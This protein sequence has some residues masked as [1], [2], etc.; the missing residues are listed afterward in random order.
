MLS[1][2]LCVMLIGL[3][4]CTPIGTSQPA[5]EL[6]PT[7]SLTVIPPTPT[8]ITPTLTDTPS[9]TPSSTHTP[10][11]TPT[12]T[13]SF[14][15]TES[16]TPTE[17]STPT[18]PPATPTPVPT[19]TATLPP[20]PLY[21]NTPLQPWE[22]EAF[23]Q[24]LQDS[25]EAVQGFYDYFGPVVGGQQGNCN[26]YW[27]YYGRWESRPGFTEVPDDWYPLYYRYRVILDNV[28]TLTDPITKV[29]SG[30]GGEVPPETD[31][32]ILAGLL[33]AVGQLDQVYAEAQ[34]H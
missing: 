34:T 9:T 23:L 14:T 7:A 22:R 21:P 6:E 3:V 20:A 29:C 8:P 30:G 28:R 15:P 24:A 2:F 5:V 12:S 33:T 11:R 4:A 19:A 31:Q 17:T 25:R 18:R 13:P 27:G 1:R 32:I 10:S 16:P 26:A